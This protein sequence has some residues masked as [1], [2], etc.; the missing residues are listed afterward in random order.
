MTAFGSHCE[1]NA[2]AFENSLVI[3]ISNS[4]FSLIS[5]ISVFGILGYLAQDGQFS[6]ASGPALLFGAYP[7][8]LATLSVHWVRFLFFNL[9]LLGLDSAFALVEAVVN[10]LED[11]SFLEHRPRYQIVMLVCAIGWFCG[12]VYTTDTAMMFVDV[13][14]FYINFVLLGL[15]FCKSFA[16][17]WVCKSDS[18]ME[19]FG[20]ELVY[21]YTLSTFG[22]LILA[23]LAWFGV[24][25]NT[26]LLGIVCWLVVYGMGLAYCWNKIKDMVLQS[27]DKSQSPRDLWFELSMGNILLLHAELQSS[28]GYIPMA[29]AICMKHFIPQVLLVLFFNLA[30]SRTPYDQW[31]LGH[32]G[33][34]VTW[35]FQVVGIS[36]LLIVLGM[37][38][39]GLSNPDTL[40]G[41]VTNDKEIKHGQVAAEADGAGYQ[42]MT[43]L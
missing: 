13:M 9:I 20:Y 27:T 34:Y 29:W 16:V 17:G 5:G 14:D 41:F 37:V 26:V 10:M 4:V 32:Y 33:D 28:V 36:V 2:P 7:A 12:L 24:Q 42:E 43:T 8:A 15:G 21:V 39:M 6:M 40:K 31:E 25:G 38:G 22:S 1:S 18:T 11:S 3:A 35:P 30:F 19:T 23:S